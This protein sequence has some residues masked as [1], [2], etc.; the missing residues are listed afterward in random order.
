MKP[1]ILAA[2]VIGLGTVMHQTSISGLPFGLVLAFLLLLGVQLPFRKKRSRAWIFAVVFS[3]GI[4]LTAL[5][6]NQ[7]AM[8]PAN[9]AGYTW[10][11]G[12]IAVSFLVAMFPRFKR[13]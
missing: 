5:E 12:A 8:I 7:D 3:I 13:N 1:A 2:A 11:F 6:T 4:F 9:P 10:S